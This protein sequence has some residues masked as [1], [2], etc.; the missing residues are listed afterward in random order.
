MRFSIILF[1][2][3]IFYSVQFIYAA[4]EKKSE[5]MDEDAIFS[6]EKTITESGKLTD[7]SAGKSVEKESLS[8]TGFLNSRT[9]YAMSRDWVNGKEGGFDQNE[10]LA[11][12][13]SNFSLDARMRKNMKGFVNVSLNYYP[14]GTT[15]SHEKS[16]TPNG[17]K[18][19]Y[20]ET[21]YTTYRVE[22]IFADINFNKAVYLRLG[23]QTLRWGTGY[24][25]VP[26]D[27][28]NVDKKNLLDASQVREGV[29][30][31]KLSIPF[32]TYL[33]FYSFVNMNKADNVDKLSSATKI[34][35]LFGKTEISI[36]ALARQGSVPVYACDFSSRLFTL[37]IHGEA[38]TS[39]GDPE[40]RLDY[41][42]P[43]NPHSYKREDKWITRAALGFG[44]AF[45]FLDIKDRVRIDAE[46]FYNG[47]GYKDNIFEKGGRIP[48][49]FVYEEKLYS[50]NYYGMY[51][52]GL[53]L[54]YNRLFIQ[55]LNFTLYY[56]QNITDESSVISCLFAYSY[57]YNVTISLMINGYTGKS[58]REYTFLGNALSAE[59]MVKLVF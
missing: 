38:S 43:A 36:S 35:A 40:K 3:I 2:A 16:D 5:A 46:F 32:G 50:P 51:Y 18:T 17:P 14:N 57:E 22:E 25:W 31:S 45:E 48:Y 15:V 12:F 10:F 24:L 56:I 52:A 29:Y 27:L 59:L 11:Y 21:E 49:Y 1:L 54:T 7:S 4:E 9:A 53:F 20:Y 30:G 34:E 26:S 41:S 39:Y 42:N 13:Q 33:N 6:D 19:T 58:Q 55:D 44:R 23:K 37:D 8:F 28:I 47:S